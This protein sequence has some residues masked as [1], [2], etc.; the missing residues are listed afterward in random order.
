M[1]VAAHMMHKCSSKH[2]DDWQQKVPNEGSEFSEYFRQL[3]EESVQYQTCKDR[4]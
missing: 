2:Q 4:P 1:N 3:R